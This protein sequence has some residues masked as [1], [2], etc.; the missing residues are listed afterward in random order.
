MSRRR[1]TTSRRPS[2]RAGP[3]RCPSGSP[4]G[5]VLSGCVRGPRR[6]RG[7]LAAYADADEQLSRF[8]AIIQ[9]GTGRA[10]HADRYHG[11][12][13]SEPLG[14]ARRGGAPADDA[15]AKHAAC[16]ARRSR[17]RVRVLAEWEHWVAGRQGAYDRSTCAASVTTRRP[18][19]KRVD[20]VA[21]GPATPSCEPPAAD[22]VLLVFHPL[23]DGQWAGFAISHERTLAARVNV[24]GP[25]NELGE[26][27]LRPFASVLGGSV[28]R[29]R[30][31][32]SSCWPASTCTTSLERSRPLRPVLGHL[33]GRRPGPPPG[34]GAREEGTH[35]RHPR[36]GSPCGDPRG[37]HRAG[38]A[39][40]RGVERPPPRR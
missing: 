3:W 27:L 12:A 23:L 19:T 25:T 36:R 2:R 20:A 38:S 16:A 31:P 40:G 28:R 21:G 34:T 30:L 4:P 22:E 39:R 35:R 33:R 9:P 15:P 5:S 8:S 32:P 10:D 26:R 37:G 13:L 11:A 29:I 24:D 6:P 18:G 17:A 1:S 7:R 14:E